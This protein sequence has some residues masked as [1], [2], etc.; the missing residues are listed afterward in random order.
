MI[1][2]IG[3]A[4]VLVM[5]FGGYLLAGGKMG[6]ILKALPFEMI[7]IGG[8]AVGAFVISNDGSSIKHTLKDVG[9][10]F[11]GPKWKPDD[12]R[13]L[14]CLLF[15]L[16]RLARANPVGLEEHIEGPAESSIFAKYPKIVADRETVALICDTLR[17]A[18]MNYDD[19]HQVEEVLEKRIEANNHHAMHSTHAL[20]TVADGLPALGIVAAVLGVIKTMASIDQPPEILGKMIGGALVG[21]F[22]GVFLAYGLVGPFAAKLKTVLEDEAHFQQ[23]IRE[24]LVANLHQHSPNICVEV[25]RQNTPTH[26]RPS[27]ADLE[28]ALK[29]TKDAA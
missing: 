6:I 15:E 10:V 8:A 3:I 5:V 4:I 9:K 23:L 20:Q 16:I 24:I 13:D 1:G 19:P 7:M 29:A 17:S 11:K 18:T 26:I 22:L 12:Y 21:T 14:M 2:L 27:F 28:E 25:G